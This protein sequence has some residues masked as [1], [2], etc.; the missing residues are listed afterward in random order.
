MTT[1][2]DV[3]D[4][5]AGFWAPP[6]DE[7]FDLAQRCAT[8]LPT[9]IRETWPILE[10]ATP[11]V[12]SWHIDVVCYHLEAVTAGELP[13]L[14]IN[15]PPRTMKSLSTCVC[16]PAWEWL[17]APAIRWLFASYAADLSTRDSLKCRR[18]IESKG[19]RETGTIFQRIGYQGVLALLSNHTWR[20]G[21][22]YGSGTDGKWSLTGDQ[23][24]KTKYENTATGMRLSTS[25][26]GVATGEGGDRIVVDDPTNA[27]QARSE[28]E[29]KAA[30]TWW[31]ETMTTR[32]NNAQAAAVIV[33]QRLH[34]SDL[35]G[36]LLASD[37]GWHHLCLPG[38]YEPSHPFVYPEKV[39]LPE[40]RYNVQ[41][42]DGRV[43][44]VVV[45]GGRVLPGD[46][47]IEEG[48]L[49]EPVRLSEPR[50]AELAKGLG[51]YGFAGQIQQRPSPEEGGMFKR[52]WWKRYDASLSRDDPMGRPDD[53]MFERMIASW[54]M[55]FSD[56]QTKA[57]S[58][59]VGQVWGQYL[60]RFYLLGQVRARLGFTDTVKAVLAV[61]A[62][63]PTITAVLV[64]RKANGEAVM[65]QLARKVTGLIPIEPEGG[66][67][68]RA[69][70]VEP[71]VEAGDIWLPA[72]EYIPAPPSIPDTADEPGVE[73]PLTATSDAIEEF[74]VFPNGANDDQVDAMSQAVTWL[75]KH[76]GGGGA[77]VKPKGKREDGRRSTEDLRNMRM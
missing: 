16:W 29:R 44:E 63:W 25:V 27:K 26:G 41:S 21:P 61:N 9:L 39:V 49:L 47:R 36:H 50:L 28:K 13:R 12:S 19:G 37:G 30:N 59:V 48:E 52:H 20:L 2:P 51:T 8:H 32:F 55:R 56:S 1:V 10:P 46:P 58:Y 7:D 69:S 75:L 53:W 5:A 14:I 57:S 42:E 60:A 4:L 24:A 31:D 73:F 76:S 54:D 3:W 15:Q 62:Q 33:M 65:S 74:A 71:N 72:T 45:P 38:R 40:R 17:S 43:D 23:N 35:T 64:E 34:E 11:Y 77:V 22:T 67:D 70:A 6:K 18:L 68:V 66:K